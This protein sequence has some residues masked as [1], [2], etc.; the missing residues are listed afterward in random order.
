[1]KTILN[2][3]NINNNVKILLKKQ[4]KKKINTYNDANGG[5]KNLLTFEDFKQEINFEE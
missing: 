2:P 4:T 1:M 5:I 3:Q